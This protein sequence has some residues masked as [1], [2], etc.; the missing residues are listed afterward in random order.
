MF[1]Y[2]K[3]VLDALTSSSVSVIEQKYYNGEEL[4]L[5]NREAL[6]NNSL[7]RSR[8]VEL[9]EPYTSTI[10]TMWGDEATIEEVQIENLEVGE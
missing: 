10:F 2:I 1:L 3:I 8:A 7:G 4:G 5:P 9:G 6:I